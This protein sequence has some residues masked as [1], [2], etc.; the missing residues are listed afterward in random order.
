MSLS[1]WLVIVLLL[2]LGLGLLV[3]MLPARVWAGMTKRGS[4][5]A[6]QTSTSA[7]LIF[8]GLGLIGVML[9]AVYSFA[10]W[11][12][13]RARNWT[14]VAA[15]VL[16][17][18]VIETR[19]IRST[20]PAYRPEVVYSYEV[21]GVAYRGSRVDFAGST[22]TDRQWVETTLRL[23]YEPGSRVTVHV[24]P[25]N[26]AESVIEPGTPA[27]ALIL[28][29]LG[30][31]FV[32]I[33]V[34][35]LLALARDWHGDRLLEKASRR[36]GQKA[37][38]NPAEAPPLP[39][40]RWHWFGRVMAALGIAVL[41]TLV[42]CV[43]GAETLLMVFMGFSTEGYRTLEAAPGIAYYGLIFGGQF[44]WPTTL[45]VLPALWLF[46]PCRN[47]RAKRLVLWGAG[48]LAGGVTMLWMLPHAP[49]DESF[50]WTLLGAGAAGGLA[51]GMVFGLFLPKTAKQEP[52]A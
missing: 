7:F 52:R 42:G 3:P 6:N 46:F 21:D 14:T 4:R 9:V 25:S 34:W 27:K 36:R 2:P 17:S 8:S 16:E 13:S 31:V 10:A 15:T 19:Q 11:Q 23:R 12:G 38:A 50:G 47:R 44:A 43:V 29:G 22:T 1:L 28:T 39:T 33:A 20:S 51:A 48:L 24:N 30:L 41:A 49:P 37:A 18:R 26:P 45:V 32:I 40:P 35:Q 5:L